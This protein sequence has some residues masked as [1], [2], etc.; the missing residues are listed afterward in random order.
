LWKF[1]AEKGVL[2][3][4]PAFSQANLKFNNIINE[5]DGIWN[6]QIVRWGKQYLPKAKII[7]YY[8][9][10]PN[11]KKAYIFA[12]AHIY[13]NIKDTGTISDSTLELLKYPRAAFKPSTKIRFINNKQILKII[14]SS[15]LFIH[16]RLWK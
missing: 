10:D 7:H 14:D 9:A 5:L 3:D 2:E 4:Q 6:C 13:K 1:S 11:V 12:N 8:N 16:K 15:F